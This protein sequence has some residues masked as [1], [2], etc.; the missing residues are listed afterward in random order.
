MLDQGMLRFINHA[1]YLLQK[2]V[3]GLSQIGRRLSK[4]RHLRWRVTDCS[5]AENAPPATR[6]LP[7][8][9]PPHLPYTQTAVVD[10]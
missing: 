6:D 2:V 10:V 3:K 4:E 1:S 7:L 5:L 8:F 9:F